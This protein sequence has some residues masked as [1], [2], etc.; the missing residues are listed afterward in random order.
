MAIMT[1]GFE[2]KLALVLVGCLKAL[3]TK[4]CHGQKVS[5]EHWCMVNQ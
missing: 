4:F 3:L 1:G 2:P 5:R